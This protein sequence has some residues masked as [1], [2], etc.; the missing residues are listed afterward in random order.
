MLSWITARAVKGGISFYSL[1]CLQQL[2][3]P[4]ASNQLR[5]DRMLKILLK[6]RVQKNP[7]IVPSYLKP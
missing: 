7:F 2:P 1:L 6:S 4:A 5:E 3:A